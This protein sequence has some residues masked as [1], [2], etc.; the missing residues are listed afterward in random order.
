MSLTN[1]EIKQLALDIRHNLVFGTWNIP[2][3]EMHMVSSIFLVAAF[4]QMNRPKNLP[5]KGSLEKLISSMN[6]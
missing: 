5:K 4:F 1:E 3:Q 2:P 6:I